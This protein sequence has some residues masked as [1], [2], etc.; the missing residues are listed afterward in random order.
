MSKRGPDEVDVACYQWAKGRR[1]Q[2][3][4]DDPRME[5]AAAKEFIGALRSTLGQRRDL[6]SGATTTRSDIHCPEGYYEGTALAVHQAYKRMP[7]FPRAI[8]ETQYVIKAPA[9]DKASLMSMDVVTYYRH[10]NHAKGIVFGWLMS[11]NAFD[12]YGAV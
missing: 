4:L 1:K 11:T 9:L 8:L 5:R 6:H 10:L 12:N 3:G 7:P 2:L